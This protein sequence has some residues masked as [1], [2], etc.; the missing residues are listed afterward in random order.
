MA[1]L[2]TNRVVDTYDGVTVD[3][4]IYVDTYDAATDSYLITHL[5]A[6][7]GSLRPVTFWAVYKNHRFTQTVAPGTSFDYTPPGNR[8]T[9]DLSSFGV[10]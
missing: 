10:A 5:A 3:M 2:Q 7:N 9:A 6:V 8:T 4:T 1:T